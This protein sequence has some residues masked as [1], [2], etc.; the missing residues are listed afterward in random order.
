MTPEFNLPCKGCGTP[1]PGI[2]IPA[3]SEII[4]QAQFCGDCKQSMFGDVPARESAKSECVRVSRVCLT[5]RKSFDG[6]RITLLGRTFDYGNYCEPCTLRKQVPDTSDPEFIAAR[7]VEWEIICP[8]FYRTPE[9]TA[10]IPGDKIKRVKEAHASKGGVWI[11][12]PS[13][14]FKTTTMLHGV[15]KPLVWQ[16]KK[17]IFVAAFEWKPRMSRAAKDCAVEAALAPYAR[18]P[19]LFLDDVG[20]MAGTASSEEALH[21]LLE[22]RMRAKLPLLLTT[23]YTGEELVGKFTHPELGA[24]IVRRMNILAGDPVKFK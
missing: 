12:G 11:Y 19:W 18:V 2:S 23:Q 3:G 17:V 22:L 16:R 7:K 14:A 6:T 21:L 5:C 9:I 15:V 20:N 24:A 8:D 10:A 4:R 1:T 13:G